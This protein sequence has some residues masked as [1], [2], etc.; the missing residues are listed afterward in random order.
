M[1]YN[2]IVFLCFLVVFFDYPIFCVFT[3]KCY[4]PTFTMMNQLTLNVEEIVVM[5]GTVKPCII[6][7]TVSG[8]K[9]L[10]V[11]FYS[12]VDNVDTVKKELPPKKDACGPVGS[13]KLYEVSS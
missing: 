11:S 13:S 4:V 3:Q 12:S 6:Y 2:I 8:Q 5:T 1:V 10:N 9:W 7:R